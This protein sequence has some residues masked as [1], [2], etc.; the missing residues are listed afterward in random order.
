MKM[1]RF[2]V[3]L[4]S[5]ALVFALVGCG[6]AGGKAPGESSAPAE[7]ISAWIVYERQVDKDEVTIY[8]YAAFTDQVPDLMF[9]FTVE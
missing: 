6:G 5:L 7:S 3:L 1:R 9:R 4:L 8:H 2:L